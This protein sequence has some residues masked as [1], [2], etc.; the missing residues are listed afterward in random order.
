MASALLDLLLADI[1]AAMKSQNTEML[2]TLRML[3]AQVKD[4]TTNAGKDPADELVAVIVAKAIKQRQDSV[5]QFKLA[6]RA[7]LADKEQREID[8]FRKYQ[9]QQLDQAAIEEIVKAVIVETGAA[10]KKDLGKVM[11]ALM[12]K[13]KGKSDGKLVNQIVQ[14]LLG[15]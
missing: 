5:E 10:G 9:P 6:G 7:D 3:H 12:P 15:G 14:A 11:Q 4:A 8:W 13:V 2:S 1:K